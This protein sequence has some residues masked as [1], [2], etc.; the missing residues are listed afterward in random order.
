MIVFKVLYYFIGLVFIFIEIGKLAKVKSYVRKMTDYTSWVKMRKK[1]EESIEWGDTPEE[2][3]IYML[4]MIIYFLSVLIWLGIGI[5]TFNWGFVLSYF[6]LMML[7]SK[8]SS[9]KRRYSKRLVAWTGFC[10]LF[11]ICFYMFLI[12]N[13]FHLHINFLELF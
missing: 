6:V 7:I 8:F 4:M 10:I 9:K 3:K 2:L 11:N 12:I 13:T 5:F 1:K